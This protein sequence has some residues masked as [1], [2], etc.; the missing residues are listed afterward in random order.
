M[1]QLNKLSRIYFSTGH[2]AYSTG[3]TSYLYHKMYH[4]SILLTVGTVQKDDYNYDKLKW[5][6]R[7][8]INTVYGMYM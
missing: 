1:P 2:T 7:L 5:L 3:H 8:N 4:G 6:D